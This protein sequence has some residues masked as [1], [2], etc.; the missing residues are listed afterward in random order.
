[1]DEPSVTLRRAD[2][3]ALPYVECLL[4]AN[5]LP[6]SD[7]RSGPGRFYVAYDGEARVGVGGIETYGTDGLLRSVAVES[8]AR[9]EGVGTA[10]CEALERAAREE[11]V[12]RLYL[13]TTTAAGFFADRGYVETER[14][15]VPEA[16]RRT[17]QFDDLC[18]EAAICMRKALQER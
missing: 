6:S 4:E 2:G 7:V 3:S 16:V 18:P 5:G 13:L 10:V 14:S 15:D 17:S 12:E 11:G 1:M 9:G 8:G